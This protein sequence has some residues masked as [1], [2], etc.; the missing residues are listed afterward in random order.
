M[1]FFT[2]IADW[3]A[4][5]TGK[6]VGGIAGL[7]LGIL[8]FTLGWKALVVLVLVLLGVLI[9]KARDDNSSITELLSGLF[10]R[11]RD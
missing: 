2:K 4:E 6:T 10:R 8:I 3:M 9:G 1:D 5:N 11:N 7:V